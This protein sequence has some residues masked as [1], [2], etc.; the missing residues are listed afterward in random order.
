MEWLIF[1]NF[2]DWF[3]GWAGS[4]LPRGLSLVVES[5][6]YSSLRCLGFSLQWLLLLWSTGSGAGRPQYL[7]HRGLGASRHV[8]SSQTQDGTQVPW[9]GRW[10]LNYFLF[11]QLSVCFDHAHIYFISHLYLFDDFCQT[12][13]YELIQTYQTE[14]AMA[15]LSSTLAWKLPWT[16]EPGSL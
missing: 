12:S 1:K 2:L 7:W 6:A 10:I 9:H 4:S 15:T 13:D 8:E 5:G 14:K 16:E 3:C 11:N